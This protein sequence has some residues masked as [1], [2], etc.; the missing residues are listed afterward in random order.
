MPDRRGND[1]TKSKRSIR[2]ARRSDCP[3]FA[4]PSASTRDRWVPVA[5]QQGFGRRTAPG[6]FRGNRRG[7]EMSSMR[8]PSSCPSA[9]LDRRSPPAGVASASW[10]VPEACPG[11]AGAPR[12]RAPTSTFVREDQ[13]EVA[14]V[15]ARSPR[16]SIGLLQ[17]VPGV[18][19]RVPAHHRRRCR[20]RADR[21]VP[22]CSPAAPF[23]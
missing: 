6:T 14:G 2:A 12:R 1:D 7:V 21:D 5:S 11:A 8:R 18:V 17:R 4:H 3:Q 10:R 13:V 19:S 20:T 15:E 16:I 9:I 23:R 22:D